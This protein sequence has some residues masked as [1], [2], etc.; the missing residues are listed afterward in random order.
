MKKIHLLLL[1]LATLLV[2]GCSTVLSGT[3]QQVHI[4]AVDV[5][6]NALVKNASCVITNGIVEYEVD[7]NPGIVTVDKGQNLSVKC[8]AKGYKQKRTGFGKSFDST[9]LVNVLFWPG[10]IVDGMSGAMH[11][12]PSHIVVEMQKNTA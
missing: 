4:K 11:K 6:N 7:S 10:F 9:S 5:S 2:S 3:S 12:Y 8:Q 1:T